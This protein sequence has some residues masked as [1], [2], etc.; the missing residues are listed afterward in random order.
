MGLSRSNEYTLCQRTWKHREDDQHEGRG[1]SDPETLGHI[2][3]LRCDLQGRADT[4]VHHHCW[5]QVQWEIE[6][7]PPES[8]GC[9]LP[10]T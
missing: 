9:D 8:K 2:Q 5:Q 7:V 6:T 4:S 3:S 1:R 10:D